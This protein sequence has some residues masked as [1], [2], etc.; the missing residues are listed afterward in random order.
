MN[1]RIKILRLRSNQGLYEA[2]R[3]LDHQIPHQRIRFNMTEINPHPFN[4]K[5]MAGI[6]LRKGVSCFYFQP[7]IANPTASPASS[8]HRL[9]TGGAEHT[10]AG[11][12]RRVP[13]PVPT[14]FN[15]RFPS[16][17]RRRDSSELGRG[18]LT[19]L[20]AGLNASYGERCSAA[21]CSR[22]AE[23]PMVLVAPTPSDVHR[24]IVVISQTHL[25]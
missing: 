2:V 20:E 19:A 16:A 25:D 9:P 1:C 13:N 8:P 6:Q 3:N 17:M 5:Q 7:S 21:V 14:T 15:S 12:R 4:C 11:H 10:T 23:F 22:D 24:S 18:L